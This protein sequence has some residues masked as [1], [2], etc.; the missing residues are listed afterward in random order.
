MKTSSFRLHCPACL[1]YN[2]S[3][4]KLKL[5]KKIKVPAAINC[6]LRDYQRQGVQ[7]LFEA[8][9]KGTGAILN[10]ESGLGKSVQVR[11]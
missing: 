3:Q 7:F 2:S 9:K 5:L 6:H 11:R 10:D 8:F 4:N 1:L